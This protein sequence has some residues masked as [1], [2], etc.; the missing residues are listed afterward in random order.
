MDRELALKF[1]RTRSQTKNKNCSEATANLAPV[2]TSEPATEA[3]SHKA[4]GSSSQEY[5]S[6]KKL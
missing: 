6:S 1:F 5:I 4:R 2:E 3:I